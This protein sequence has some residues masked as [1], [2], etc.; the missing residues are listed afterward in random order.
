[1]TFKAKKYLLN[2]LMDWFGNDIAFPD[3]TETDVTA[4]VRVNLNTMRM[5]ALQYALHVKVLEPKELAEQIRADLASA[6]N[7]YGI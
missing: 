6:L 1:M 3:E 4:S 7:S 5:W 2:D